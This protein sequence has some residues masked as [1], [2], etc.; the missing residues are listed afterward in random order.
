MAIATIDAIVADVMLVTEL[1]WLLAL[2]PLTGVPSGS[3]DLCRYP[4]RREQDKNRAV[5]RGPRQIV[6]AM[7]ENLWHRRRKCVHLKGGLC[8]PIAVH[9]QGKSPPLNIVYRIKETVTLDA[10][11]L[12]ACAD[13]F[14]PIVDSVLA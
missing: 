1:D 8:P 13:F 6:R 5:D 3:G 11:T 12:A 7:T 4:K 14:K 10:I 9:G 2:D